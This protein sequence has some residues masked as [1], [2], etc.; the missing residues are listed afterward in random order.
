[1]NV[2]LVSV[3]IA[4]VV[5]TIGFL[6][7]IGDKRAFERLFWAWIGD[8]APYLQD[9]TTAS[10]PKTPPMSPGTRQQGRRTGQHNLPLVMVHTQ[11]HASSLNL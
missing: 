10:K 3:L 9:K 6:R 1:M 7:I 4:L 8:L 2:A 5:D 11:G